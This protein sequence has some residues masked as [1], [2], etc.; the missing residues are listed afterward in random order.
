MQFIAEEGHISP[1]SNQFS[2]P[3]T[4][5]RQEKTVKICSVFSGKEA[6]WVEYVC[7][8]GRMWVSVCVW[9]K[10]E[11][12]CHKRRRRGSTGHSVADGGSYVEERDLGKAQHD[13]EGTNSK[14]SPRQSHT[15]RG[16]LERENRLKRSVGKSVSQE[17]RQVLRW[18]GV[19]WEKRWW[20]WML[21]YLLTRIPLSKSQSTFL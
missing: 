8:N 13:W 9:L 10:S 4:T 2:I 12:N 3:C 7:V 11:R 1:A 19:R 14:V 15:P 21:G 18:P 17:F 20:I 5:S 16:N 6:R